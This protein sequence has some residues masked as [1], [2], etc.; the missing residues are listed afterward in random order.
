MALARKR[1]AASLKDNA[2]TGRAGI[3]E[4]EDT[5]I[6][7]IQNIQVSNLAFVELYSLERQQ[8]GPRAVFALLYL[9]SDNFL[10]SLLIVMNFT[11]NQ[12]YPGSYFWIGCPL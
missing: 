10:I 1:L 9:W 3:S 8:R 11:A 12:Q 4:V 2:W 6:I 7:R 5:C